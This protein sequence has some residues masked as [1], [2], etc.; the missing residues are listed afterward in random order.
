MRASKSKRSEPD[1]LDKA[2]ENVR[3][4]QKSRERIDLAAIQ[5]LK[6]KFKQTCDYTKRETQRLEH[7]RSAKKPAGTTRS[8]TKRG[9]IK[10]AIYSDGKIINRGIDDAQSK[11]DQSELDYLKKTIG[12]FKEVR[13]LKTEY[14]KYL[15][16]DVFLPELKDIKE[17]KVKSKFHDR[18][19]ALSGISRTD[20]LS[21][22]WTSLFTN[23]QRD[24]INGL[25]Q[26]AFETTSK[27][28][29]GDI[30]HSDIK[31]VGIVIYGEVTIRIVK[32]IHKFK[33]SEEAVE[34]MIKSAREAYG[35]DDE[36][37]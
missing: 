25:L 17:G 8:G 18:Y 26:G 32:F 33:T 30:K 16:V 2:L 19:H 3:R 28:S 11:Y 13:E 31:Y 35:F 22:V 20:L 6:K 23:E 5:E 14:L 7:E 15:V 29:S 1:D 24:Y 34:F 4:I 10:E 36:D 27:D 21:E 12:K 9:V 37:D